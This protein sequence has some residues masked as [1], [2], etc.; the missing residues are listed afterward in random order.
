MQA[1]R[2][3]LLA[4]V[5]LLLFAFVLVP[6]PKTAHGSATPQLVPSRE[7]PR[8]EGL[9]S[10]TGKFVDPPAFPLSASGTPSY[11]EQIG[12]SFAQSF[13]SMQY[14]VSAVAQSDPTTGV[15][16]AYLLQG[17]TEEGYWYQVGLLYNWPTVQ[18][19]YLPGFV[20]GYEVFD[21]NGISVYPFSGAG[22]SYLSGPVNEGDTV[23]LNLYFG[24]LN[25]MAG[26]VVMQA[27]DRNTGAYASASFGDE[28]AQEFVG[29]ASPANENGYFTGLMTEWYRPGPYY[30]NEAQVVYGGGPALP[31]A[32]MWI[33]EF[34]Y[35]G[36]TVLFANSTFARYTTD[37]RMLREFA[38]NGATEYSNAITLVTGALRAAPMTL[39]YTVQGG[40]TSHGIPTIH[41]YQLGEPLTET[42]GSTP[43]TFFVDVGSHWSISPTLTGSGENERWATGQP[44]TGVAQDAMAST[45]TYHHQYLASFLATFSSSTGGYSL[46]SIAYVGLG[47]NRTTEMGSE[48]WVDAGSA[49]S[50]TNPLNGS[51]PNERWFAGPDAAGI[52]NSSGRVSPIYYHQFPVTF[53]YTVAGGTNPYPP[54][55]VGSFLGSSIERVLKQSGQTLWFDAGTSVSM[56]DQLRGSNSSERW[57]GVAHIGLVKGPTNVAVAYYHQF[58]V[59]V[60]SLPAEGG[61]VTASGWRNA[62][63]QFS[64][65]AMP[66]PGWQFEGWTGAGSASYTGASKNATITLSSPIHENATFYPEVTV[67]D[68][69]YGQVSYEWGNA[70]VTITA[71]HGGTF[72]PQG[73]I[74]SFE[75]SPSIFSSF[76]GYKGGLNSTSP[77]ASVVVEGPIQVEAVFTLNYII[78]GEVAAVMVAA[79]AGTTYA[80]R[81]RARGR[82]DHD[83]V[84]SR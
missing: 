68:G 35:P 11:D 7:A 6:L 28:R 69:A 4:V 72:V 57:Y 50:Y 32:W 15:G 46:P 31:G 83:N 25:G 22:V 1:R 12:M 66:S 10:E 59:T 40:G 38:S 33:D 75:A 21:P 82:R 76:V 29:M 64:L 41:Y 13:Y 24:V 60:Q 67:T 26:Q 44:S 42:I 53:S 23:T 20:M 43:T 18:G 2:L 9:N 54:S 78:I 77:N 14:N 34:S 16:P 48:V 62:S 39:S 58:Y 49:Y 27:L 3:P 70:S 19:G 17:L 84:R 30:G 81:V 79:V 5:A 55:A 71:G 61:S 45:Y 73:T 36:G 51:E 8:I 56:P 47:L 80:M 52:A 65:T 63:T 37:A 74:V